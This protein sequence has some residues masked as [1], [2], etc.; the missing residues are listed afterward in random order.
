MLKNLQ[1]ANLGSS[2]SQSEMFEK[3]TGLDKYSTKW[4]YKQILGG[5]NVPKFLIILA[6]SY[7]AATRAKLTISIQK[8]LVQIEK[9]GLMVY[10]SETERSKMTW[11]PPG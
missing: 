2:D 9:N 10:F 11:Q 7:G 5:K 3:P 6:Y 1:H 8:K 4:N